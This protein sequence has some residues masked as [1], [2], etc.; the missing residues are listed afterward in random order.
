M[1]HEEISTMIASMGLPYAYN[2]FSDK[3]GEHPQGPP[4]ICFLYTRN[5]DF[6]ADNVPYARA[7]ALAIELNT[8]EADF[9]LEQTVEAVLIANELP[10]YKEQNFIESERMYQTTYT[11]E[12]ILDA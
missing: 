9:E 6:D 11:T 3:D 10:F 5:D 2:Q 4:Y 7:T 8:E 12:V 1:T